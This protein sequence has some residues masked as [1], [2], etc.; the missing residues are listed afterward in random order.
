MFS[1][2]VIRLENNN[3]YGSSD[4]YKN[5]LINFRCE[6][7]TGFKSRISPARAKRGIDCRSDNTSFEQ[8][9]INACPFCPERI[10]SETP[11][12]AGNKRIEIGES[13]TF[14]NLFPFSKTHVVTVITKEHSP[15]SFTKRQIEDAL[16]AQYMALKD[17]A[18]YPSVNWNNLSSAG[19]SMIHPHMQGI[20]DDSPSYV[21]GVYIKKSREYFLKN[22][23]NYW[24]ILSCCEVNS[25]RYLFGDEIVW[26][27]NPVPFGEKE[28]RGYMPVSKI[29]D[30]SEYVDLLSSDILKIIDYYKKS[31]H[32]AYNMTIR[33]DKKD[34][35]E[36]FK[37]FVSVIARINPT[38][39]STSDSAYM[40]RLNFEPVVLTIPEEIGADYRHKCR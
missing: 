8:G 33:F 17:T 3:L 21:T 13:V 29:C 26:S 31:G 7:L 36:S 34:S 28:I 1:E 27:A 6:T 14:P 5:H 18:G 37:A 25:E 24:D 40:E 38:P 16:Q 35:D 9:K 22:N 39:D 20:S 32:F 2:S 4:N 30:F 11:V 10:Y 23:K 12:F 15:D 19:A